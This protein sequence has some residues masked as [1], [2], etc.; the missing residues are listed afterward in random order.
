MPVQFV[1]GTAT[2]YAMASTH[3]GPSASTALVGAIE[4][5]LQ[6]AV[7]GGYAHPQHIS[8]LAAIADALEGMSLEEIESL[9]GRTHAQ[10]AG[11]VLDGFS[12]K[13]LA[14]GALKFAPGASKLIQFV[15]GL[16]PIASTALDIAAKG[17]SS[18]L[19]DR[20]RAAPARAPQG[21]GTPQ[22]PMVPPP[23][24]TNPFPSVEAFARQGRICIPATWE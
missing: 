15:P 23:G 13:K 22:S 9:Y 20:P 7:A 3:A 10:A 11:E 2:D 21:A 17:A 18:V 5:A 6:L 19:K 1:R 16:G 24:P 4:G 14:K 12:L 8:R